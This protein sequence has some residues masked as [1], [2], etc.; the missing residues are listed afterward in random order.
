MTSIS[1]L[2]RMLFG[3][4]GTEKGSDIDMSEHGRAGG[5]STGQPFK[6]VSITNPGTGESLVNSDSNAIRMTPTDLYG[7]ETVIPTDAFGRL[8][9]ATPDA[10]FDNMF[11]YGLNSMFWETSVTNGSVTHVANN[12]AMRLS[13]GGTAAN[14]KAIIQTKKYMRYQPGRSLNMEITF[15][16]GAVQTNSY[17]RI[18]YFDASNGVFLERSRDASTTTFKIVRRTNVSG[19]PSDN[20]G[21]AQADWNV[22][23]MDGSGVSGKS[24]DFTKSQIM[25]IQLQ[26]LGVGRIQ[27]GFVVDGVNYVAHEFLNSNVLSTVYMSTGCL[28]VRAEVN[29]TGT[30]GGTLTM[31]VFCVSVSTGGLGQE[32]IQHSMSNGIVPIN[33]S[34][35]LLP[36]LSIRAA[37]LLG[38]TAGGGSL[39]NRGHIEPIEM[40]VTVGSQTHEYQII[41]NATLTNPSW[42][43][44]GATSLADY[45]ISATGISGGT[46][47][48]R[49]YVVASASSRGLDKEFFNINPLVYT[50]LNST[51]DILTIAARTLTGSGTALSAM[52]W[53]EQY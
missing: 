5:L 45:D 10:L 31:D 50:G 53:K 30:S 33:T 40:S 42:V 19:T 16:M 11:E 34:T 44:V 35:T 17:A 4:E 26:F 47:L 52:T 8:K 39:T 38:G 14:N 9:V 43:A 41:R 37:T 18:G 49:G 23:R 48:D 21:V 36:I 1:D 13:T 7:R 20:A 28:P 3:R 51:Q 25:F 32:Q 24:L 46:V 22:D 27:V 2:Y 15:C 12:C 6:H 29:N